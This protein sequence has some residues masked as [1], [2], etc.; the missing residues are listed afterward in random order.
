M[1]VLV[2]PNLETGV[3]YSRNSPPSP[4]GRP[5]SSLLDR[6]LSELAGVLALCINPSLFLRL[7]LLCATLYPLT[8]PALL[9]VLGLASALVTLVVVSTPPASKS[10]LC[11]VALETF[12]LN[13]LVQW[14][15]P[16][17]FLIWK[18]DPNLG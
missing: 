12:A 6:V 16:F 14:W 8:L 5:S 15:V 17:S 9:A 13:T 4:R 18:S 11:S 1:C 3:A 2:I 7:Q 10:F